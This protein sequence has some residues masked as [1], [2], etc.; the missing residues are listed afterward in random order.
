MAYYVNSGH[1]LTQ[2]GKVVHAGQEIPEKI[3]EQLKRNKSFDQLIG[4]DTITETQPKLDPVKDKKTGSSK[5]SKVTVP[6][7]EPQTPP[8]ETI[9]DQKKDEENNKKKK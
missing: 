8:E 6:T 5:V 4:N 2:E 1:S 7:K 3:I 9:T